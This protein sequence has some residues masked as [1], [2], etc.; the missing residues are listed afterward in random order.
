MPV[1]GRVTASR[2]DESA[3][4]APRQKVT[5]FGGTLEM[6]ATVDS[7]GERVP[8]VSIQT[9]VVADSVGAGISTTCRSAGT[10]KFLFPRPVW[11]GA[12]DRRRTL[13]ARQCMIEGRYDGDGKWAPTVVARAARQ[14]YDGLA[15]CLLL[16]FV[17]PVLLSGCGGG[18]SSGSSNPPHLSTISGVISPASYGAG[19][20]VTLTGAASATTTADVAGHYSFSGLTNGTYTVTPI[21]S[22]ATFTPANR[23]VTVNNGD[24]SAIDFTAASATNTATI[25][26]AISPAS[27]GASSTVTLTGPVSATTTADAAGHYSFSGLTNGTYTVTPS[28]STATFTPANRQVTV[29]NGDV[30][31]IDFTATANANLLFFDDFV[32][33]SLGSDWTVIERRGP[34][35]QSENECN[36]A[37]AVGVSNGTVIITTSALPATCG[38]A[39]TAPTLLPYTSGDIQWANQSF[40]YGTVEIRAKL[41]PQNT[42]TWPAIWLLGA[43][44]QAAN[45]LNGSE[46]VPYL[47]CPAQGDAAYQEID[48]VECDLRGWCHIVVAQGSAG[49]SNM[50][51]FPVDANWHVFTLRWT[52]STVSISV[53]GAPTGC[54]YPN[55]SLHGP[56]FLIVQTQTTTASGVGGLPNNARLPTTFQI[57]Y[58]KVTQ[59]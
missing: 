2:G 37:G 24:V 7:A 10:S 16:L 58:V 26:G 8:Q 36:T 44:C 31:A 19:S 54:S 9:N 53:D 30:S 47:G 11:H 42:G 50:C 1:L 5:R 25:S 51:S 22:T 29:N 34:A 13:A 57:D 15:V 56:M 33:A 27:Y 4:P 59:P 52:N 18:S 40:T 49:W 23:Q 45:V 46:S 55:T 12:M 38:D 41:P 32:G 14:A 35:G 28:S 21:S 3:Y 43:N 20:T 17:T 48:M 39:V 6:V